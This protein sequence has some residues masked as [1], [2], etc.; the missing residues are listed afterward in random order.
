MRTILLFILLVAVF[1]SSVAAEEVVSVYPVQALFISKT[2]NEAFRKALSKDGS[3]SDRSFGIEAFLEEFKRNFPN[4]ADKIDDSNK[5]TTFAAYVEIPRVS[6]YEIKKT[7]QLT[8]IYLPITM[9]LTFANMVTGESLYSYAYTYYSPFKTTSDA[10]ADKEQKIVELYRET[11]R[12][13]L[14]K[15]IGQA[16]Q[17]F[18][19]F[20]IMATVKK[21]WN[22]YYVLDRG[23]DSGVVKGDILTDQY[24]NPLRV[25]YSSRKYSVAQKDLG[26]PKKES[27]F[28][29]V[30]NQSID[31]LKKPKVML[32]LNKEGETYV[33]SKAVP[34]TI[35]YQLFV[36]ALGKKA[37]FSLV[38]V[39]PSFGEVQTSVNEL[40]R[41][42]QEVTQ[43]REMPDYFLKL[44]FYG[45]FYTK[46]PTNKPHV[47]VDNYTMIVCGEFLDGNGRILYGKCVDDEKI[48]DE[49]FGTIRYS[50]EAREEILV[51][52]GIVKLADDLARNIKFHALQLPVLKTEANNVFIEDKHN[53]LAP[54][55][56]LVVFKKLDR[57]EGIDEDLYVPVWQLN[58]GMKGSDVAVA[59]KSLALSSKAPGPGT[60]DSI[61]ADMVGS[62]DTDNMKVLQV[63]P[64]GGSLEG[65]Y[66]PESIEKLFPFLL[67]QQVKYPFYDTK[68]F[69]EDLEQYNG[70]RSGGF[71][72]KR[73]MQ[74]HEVKSDYCVEPVIKITKQT[75]TPNR[76][77]TTY[78]FS[79]VQGLKVYKNTDVVWKKGLQ[80]DVT[81]SAPVGYDRTVLD[82]ELTRR[83]F[84]LMSNEIVKNIELRE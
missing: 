11:Y 55:Q 27:V 22:D 31:Q 42:S 84:T 65:E 44:Y 25:I 40:T 8:D 30:S 82:F 46:L 50:N 17:G 76:D 51:K 70:G 10:S 53:A 2:A 48:A 58:V 3:G 47:S 7:E 80:Q 61:F 33:K 79:V 54:G 71:G 83:V 28:S 13:L 24:M 62:G 6:R 15:V 60:G 57:L 41:L 69:S 81:V 74:V 78:K 5:Y 1:S 43:K 72:F 20:S 77:F 35:V 37:A 39:D 23:T 21:V 67:S 34:D 66:V 52:N 12:D 45:P 4:A 14:T 68:H 26:E 64:K 29:K 19:P 32:L 75:E 49:V 18:A 16:K 59:S 9:S 73:Q 63:C 36:D 56:N 38:S